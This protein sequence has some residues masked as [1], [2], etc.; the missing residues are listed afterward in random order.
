MNEKEEMKYCLELGQYIRGLAMINNF[1]KQYFP[2]NA[3]FIGGEIIKGN[4]SPS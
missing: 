3:Q 2:D 1:C 4:K